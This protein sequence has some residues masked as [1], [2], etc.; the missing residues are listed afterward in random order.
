MICGGDTEKELEKNYTGT[1]DK[2]VEDRTRDLTDA[3]R[4]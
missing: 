3:R 2:T 1:L 4:W